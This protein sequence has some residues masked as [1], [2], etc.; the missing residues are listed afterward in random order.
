MDLEITEWSYKIF[1]G[2]APH[3]AETRFLLHEAFGANAFSGND[4]PI[5]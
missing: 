4:N 2:F 5:V 3:S 1:R